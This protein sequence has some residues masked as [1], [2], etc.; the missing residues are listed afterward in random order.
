M[1]VRYKRIV[2]IK[3]YLSSLK[4]IL[5]CFQLSSENSFTLKES[6]EKSQQKIRNTTS[7]I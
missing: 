5:N 7:T 1:G 4:E 6:Y 2:M 3:I